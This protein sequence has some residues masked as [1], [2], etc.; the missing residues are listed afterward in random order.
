MIAEIVTSL[1]RASLIAAI[2]LGIW[3]WGRFGPK[4]AWYFQTSA[5]SVVF[6]VARFWYYVLPFLAI[7]FLLAGVDDWLLGQN[8]HTL[9]ISFFVGIG[10]V[11]LG[12]V[13]GFLQP[14]WLSPS[15]LRRLKREHGDV[16]P[17]LIEDA[18]GMEK[19]ELEQRLETWESLER[20][21]AD[22]RHKHGL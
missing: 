20:W 21:V 10:C 8:P 12:F 2:P 3:L 19:N 15:W 6:G 17:K 22:A 5:T 9:P 4:K 13:C 1:L 14:D 7:A 11:V 18:V 16:I